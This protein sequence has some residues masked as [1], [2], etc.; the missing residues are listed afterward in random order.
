M[1]RSGQKKKKQKYKTDNQLPLKQRD[2]LGE[3]KA[4]TRVLN[5]GRGRREVKSEKV[6]EELDLILLA[7]KMEGDYN[8]KNVS[9][10]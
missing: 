3:S 10:L 6:C 1:P 4:I 9:S 7:L 8:P 5:C 2:Y